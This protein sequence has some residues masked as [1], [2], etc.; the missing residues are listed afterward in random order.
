MSHLCIFVA[1]KDRFARERTVDLIIRMFKIQ[2]F[3]QDIRENLL[4][5][6]VYVFS[7]F[8]IHKYY[9]CFNDH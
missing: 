8:L 2:I 3:T 6:M 9:G 1:V 5:H 7:F 4:S